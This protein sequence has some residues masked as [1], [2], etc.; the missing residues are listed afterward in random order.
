MLYLKLIFSSLN[1]LL[2][3]VVKL[4]LAPFKIPQLGKTLKKAIVELHTLKV[5]Y[6]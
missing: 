1:V 4:K 3:T 2:V 6:W 5:C